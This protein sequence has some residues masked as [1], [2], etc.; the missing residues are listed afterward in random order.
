MWREDQKPITL[1]V[2]KDRLDGTAAAAANGSNLDYRAPLMGELLWRNK[3]PISAC[4][5]DRY[6]I[7]VYA[8]GHGNT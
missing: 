4:F 2:P 5:L 6:E 7:R 3:Y 1:K 8:Q